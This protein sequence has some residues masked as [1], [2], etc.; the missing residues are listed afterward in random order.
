FLPDYAATTIVGV[1]SGGLGAL[2]LAAWFPFRFAGAA[3]IAPWTDDR[4]E[5]PLGGEWPAWEQLQR[6]AM[7]PR[8]LAINFANVPVLLHHPEHL[9]GLDG[10]DPAHEEALKTALAEFQIPA[11][12]PPSESAAVGNPAPAFAAVAKWLL[13][14]RRPPMIGAFAYKAGASRA[15]GD[16]EFRLEGRHDPALAGALLGRRENDSWRVQTQNVSR[17]NLRARGVARLK[18]DNQILPF[19]PGS[20]IF[21][22]RF[23]ESWQKVDPAPIDP[24]SKF[25]ERGGPWFD[26]FWDGLTIVPGTAGPD[27]E[28]AALEVLAE[29]IRNRILSGEDSPNLYPGDRGCDLEVAIMTDAE[30]AERTPD[31]GSLLILGAPRNNLLLARWRTEFAVTWPDD[32][33]DAFELAGKRYDE[34]AAG[35]FV[36][37]PRPDADSGYAA[38]G[39]ATGIG[40]LAGLDAA[41][42]SFLPDYLVMRRKQAMNWGWFADDWR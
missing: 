29:R 7:T 23:G 40:G 17:F 34:S 27:L 6:K 21:C 19:G 18:V 9:H 13:A 11:A 42:I 22:E 10:A 32:D 1:G 36:L 35:A 24:A 28:T 38:I 37:Q 14:R 25:S 5:T 8:S 2:Q 3:A 30:A 4:L 26:L 20:T 33:S 15:A 41:R 39:T 16:G 12:A 31:S